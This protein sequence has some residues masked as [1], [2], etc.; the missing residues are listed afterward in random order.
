ID[1]SGVRNCWRIAGLFLG[2][3]YVAI[4]LSAVRYAVG[5]TAAVAACIPVGIYHY[6]K[7]EYDKVRHNRL[8]S[9]IKDDNYPEYAPQQVD[10]SLVFVF[11]LLQKYI[12]KSETNDKYR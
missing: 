6:D 2:W 3:T 10:S 9:S 7:K 4:A 1:N 8:S 5:L 12:L 11:E